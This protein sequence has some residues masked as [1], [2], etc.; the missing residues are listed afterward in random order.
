M[1]LLEGVPHW[2]LPRLLV[3]G[4]ASYLGRLDDFQGFDLDVIT[5]A[6][7]SYLYFGAAS[8]V[9]IVLGDLLIGRCEI[10][11]SDYRRLAFLVLI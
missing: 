5:A 11:S 3:E 7:L 9:G 10:I 6:R 8:Y 4:W 1:S 2:L